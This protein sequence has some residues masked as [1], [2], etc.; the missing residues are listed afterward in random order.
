MDDSA[1]QL[2]NGGHTLSSLRNCANVTEVRGV[3]RVRNISKVVVPGSTSVQPITR[4]KSYEN[5]NPC[6]ANE[7][8]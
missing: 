3:L 8:N 2:I 4:R 5:F 1:L 6:I 7:S